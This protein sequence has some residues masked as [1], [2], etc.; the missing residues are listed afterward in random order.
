VKQS[1]CS[2][3]LYITEREQGLRQVREVLGY[4]QSLL[5]QMLETTPQDVLD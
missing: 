4:I 1:L 3:V 2:E 5:I